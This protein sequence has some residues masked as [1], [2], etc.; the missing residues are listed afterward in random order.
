VELYARQ[1]WRLPA[2]IG[3]VYDSAHAERALGFRCETDFAAILDSLR[4]GSRL[5]FSHDAAYVSPQAAHS[6]KQ[7]RR[8]D[9]AI[10]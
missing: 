2:L 10:R 8:N 5:P 4:K 7:Q 1:G 9:D 3:R 6:Q